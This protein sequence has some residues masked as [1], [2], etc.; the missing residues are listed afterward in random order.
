MEQRLNKDQ[1]TGCGNCL[2]A[3]PLDLL[4]LSAQ[5]NR[6]GVC[7]V[8]NV[9]PQRCIACRRCELMCTAGAIDF[10]E[11]N[12]PVSNTLIDKQGNPAACGLLSWFADKSVG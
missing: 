1:C 12:Q 9:D 4:R 7:F 11:N 8:E 3:C 6:R 5:H 2:T 10:L